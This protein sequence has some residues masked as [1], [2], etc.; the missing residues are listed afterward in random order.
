MSFHLAGIVPVAGQDLDF[1]LPW[2]DALIPI[3]KNYLAVERAV[4]EC[5]TV[6]CETIWIVCNDDM[7]PLIRHV[8][9]ESVC[10]PFWV[11]RKNKLE[12]GRDIPIFYVPIHPGDRGR[13]DSLGWSVIEGAMTAMKVTLG[14]SRWTKPDRYYASFP[15]G[16]YPINFLYPLRKRISS[17]EP[18]HVPYNGKTIK[19]GEFLAFTFTEKELKEMRH[20]IFKE[21]TGIKIG[22]PM[23]ETKMLAMEERYSAKHFSID[24]IFKSV[25]LSGNCMDEPLWY[26]G[27]DSWEKYSS[28]MSSGEQLLLEKPE[29]L[30]Y[31]EFNPIGVDNV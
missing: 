21:G 3:G 12:Q 29:I 27:I 1:H 17:K 11:Q 20:N 7:E 23:I 15:Y 18:F 22:N 5:A 10:D 24:K 13:R 14:I 19:D 2:H 4:A 28:Y 26:Y 30:G 9:G 8:L 31:K 25:T 16:V 6:G